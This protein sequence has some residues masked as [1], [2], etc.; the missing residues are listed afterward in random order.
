MANVCEDKLRQAMCQQL[1]R[2]QS[3]DGLTSFPKS[4]KAILSWHTLGGQGRAVGQGRG[5][6]QGW[7][8]GQGQGR[9]VGYRNCGAWS[10]I[11]SNLIS[12][13]IFIVG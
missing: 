11:L 12:L 2:S 5:R 4:S 7:V 9:G 8:E 13:G 1:K 6:G 10:D 3:L